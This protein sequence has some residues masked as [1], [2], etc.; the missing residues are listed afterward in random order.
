MWREN[1]ALTKKSDESIGIILHKFIDGKLYF[2]DNFLHFHICISTNG[3]TTIAN[4]LNRKNNSK[5]IHTKILQYKFSKICK[6]PFNRKILKFMNYDDNKIQHR[7]SEL[8]AIIN[9]TIINSDHYHHGMIWC[10]VL[11]CNMDTFESIEYLLHSMQLTLILHLDLEQFGQL[12][13]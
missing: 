10:D 13:V 5:S 2:T 12:F 6:L 8:K 3:R 11:P 7:D 4:N 9:I 1:S